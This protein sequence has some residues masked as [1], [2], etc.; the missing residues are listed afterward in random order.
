MEARAERREAWAETRATRAAG[1]LDRADQLAGAIP[2]G[3]PI[4]VGHHSE[5]RDRNYRARI[6]GTMDRAVQGHRAAEHH[7]RTADGIRTQLRTSIYDDD[8]DAI[9]QLRAKLAKLE[10]E[11]AAIK[12]RNKAARTVGCHCPDDCACRSQWRETICGCHNHTAPAYLLQN[13]SGNITRT[14]QRLAR[15]ERNQ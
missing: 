3:Q 13:L 12:D 1:D 8:P 4:L 14:R 15:L 7:A 10:A 6:A 2:F 11:R 9:E 5:R